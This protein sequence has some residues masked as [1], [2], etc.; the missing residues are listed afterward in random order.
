MAT[1]KTKTIDPIADAVKQ[2]QSAA[3]P[4]ENYDA[5]KMV[6]TGRKVYAAEDLSEL[7]DA[8]KVLASTGSVNLLKPILATATVS[9]ITM[10]LADDGTYVLSGTSTAA[11]S[12]PSM[13]DLS[14]L[15]PLVGQEVTLTGGYSNSIRLAVY[16]S[17]TSSI[18]MYRDTGAGVT[19]T[20]TQDI[21][22]TADVRIAFLSGAVATDVVIK[23]MIKAAAL[24]DI[25]GD[26][27][28]PYA[29]SNRELYTLIKSL[30]PDSNLMK[31]DKGDVEE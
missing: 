10:T 21:I 7:A 24:D 9:G 5:G 20:L 22:D 28:Y 1:K 18:V 29:P 31:L 26:T 11:G 19:F 8:C 17:R 23:P 25:L 2:I 16:E 12:K 4:L 30:H 6:D 3:A 14:S 13:F 15:Q 27:Y